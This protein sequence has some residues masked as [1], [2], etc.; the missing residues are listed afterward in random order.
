MINIQE[1]ISTVMSIKNLTN[2]EFAHTIG[3]QPSNISHIL[4]GRNKPSLDLI[5]KIVQRFPEIR[6]DWLLQGE[7]SMNKEYGFELFDNKTAVVE[8][9]KKV[10]HLNDEQ[11]A[12]TDK[13]QSQISLA[14][15]AKKANEE[16]EGA[17]NEHDRL[18]LK[19]SE[20]GNRKTTLPGQ[21]E[22]SETE[23]ER[24][25]VF[26]RNKTFSIYHPG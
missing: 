12:N 10:T 23:I 24:I 17:Q 14:F 21:E 4:S 25:V 20:S 5:M 13:G 22:K 7:G 11:I 2:A 1:R 16:V 9:P 3:V 19:S 18:D 8:V 6:L 15:E 26:Y